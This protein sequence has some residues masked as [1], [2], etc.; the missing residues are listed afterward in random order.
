MKNLKW[1]LNAESS[2]TQIMFWIILIKLFSGLFVI[3]IG[4]LFIIGN[5]YTLLKSSSKLSKDYFN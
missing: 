2:L 5:I 4:S 3:V 1:Q